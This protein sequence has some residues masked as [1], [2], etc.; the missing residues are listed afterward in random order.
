MAPPHLPIERHWHALPLVTQAPGDD[1]DSSFHVHPGALQTLR[2]ASAVAAGV[3]VLGVWGPRHTGKRLFLRTLLNA[4]AVTFGNEEE[5]PSSADVL[6]WLWVPVDGVHDCI[7][8]SSGSV[9]E[10]ESDRR[11]CARL[12]LLL[13]LASALVFCD[14]GELGARALATLDWLPDVARVLRVRGNQDEAS[15]GGCA[16]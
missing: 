8:V 12:A 11:R 15:V 7:V 4:S 6:L 9:R 13:L 5:E 2:S 10:D 1:S 3:R 16:A 14:D